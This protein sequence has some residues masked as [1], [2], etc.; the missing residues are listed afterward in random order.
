METK[1]IIQRQFVLPFSRFLLNS[2]YLHPFALFQ[3]LCNKEFIMQ[4][5]REIYD[6]TSDT[7]TRSDYSVFRRSN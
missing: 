6:V 5:L 7:L 2:S 4:A 1:R 3:N